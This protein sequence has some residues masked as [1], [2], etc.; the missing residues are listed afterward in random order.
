MKPRQE[1]FIDTITPPIAAVLVL[2]LLLAI[3]LHNDPSWAAPEY[4]GQV[5]YE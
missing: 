3:M 1:D 2:I 5:V 4:V